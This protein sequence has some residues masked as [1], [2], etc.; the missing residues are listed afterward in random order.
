MLKTLKKKNAEKKRMRATGKITIFITFFAR[1]EI[2]IKLRMP[3]DIA[4]FEI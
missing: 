2:G 3:I 4:F 1:S